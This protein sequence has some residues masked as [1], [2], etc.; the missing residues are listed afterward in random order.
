VHKQSKP[1][2]S[3]TTSHQ[4]EGLQPYPAKQGS[5]TVGGYLGRQ[6]LSL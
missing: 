1:R 2:N 3:V 4:H 6:K 5:I